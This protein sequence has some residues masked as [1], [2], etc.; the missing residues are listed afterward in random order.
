[1]FLEVGPTASDL[2]DRSKLMANEPRFGFAIAYVPDIQAAKRFY[3]DK[4]G[5]EVEAEF[6][7]FVQFKSKAGAAFAVAPT[8]DSMDGS[9]QTELWW[10]V[11]DAEAAFADLSAKAEVS[12]APRQMP[13]GKCFGVKDA[14]GQPRYFLELPKPSTAGAQ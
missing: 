6:P 7:N 11:E 13:F 8:A 3:V 12:A 4:L 1:M 14:A 9:G 2:T 10:L 5:L